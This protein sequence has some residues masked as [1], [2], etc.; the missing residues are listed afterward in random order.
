MIRTRIDKSI[1]DVLDLLEHLGIKTAGADYMD[2]AF[3]GQAGYIDPF[4]D[5]HAPYDPEPIHTLEDL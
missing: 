5:R 1:N 3:P 2:D 4:V